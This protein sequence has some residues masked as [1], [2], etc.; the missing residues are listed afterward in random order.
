MPSR[1]PE[2]RISAGNILILRGNIE[3]LPIERTT[4][5]YELLSQLVGDY[6]VTSCHGV[7]ISAALS[8]MPSTTSKPS[9]DLS[10]AARMVLLRRN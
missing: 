2:F 7:D 4:V 3:I 6:L 1:S 10:L 5:S 8:M 9:L